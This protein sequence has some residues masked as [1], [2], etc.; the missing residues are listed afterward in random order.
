MD[1]ATLSC[2]WLDL[3]PA[4]PGLPD[5]G[6]HGLLIPIAGAPALRLYQ[7]GKVRLVTLRPGQA[8]LS[9]A[10]SGV[11][12]RAAT[13]F[14]ALLVRIEPRVLADF[15]EGRMYGSLSGGGLAD[16]PVLDDPELCTVARQ[17]AQVLIAGAFGAGVELDALSMVFM[18][19]LTRNHGL[20]T[21]GTRPVSA[22]LSGAQLSRLDRYVVENL[23]GRIHRVDMA[24]AAGTSLSGLVR[25]L[26][27]ALGVTP[28]QYVLHARL[29]AAR[30]RMQDPAASLKAI[31]ADCGFADQA[32]L[33]RAFKARFGQPP[34]AWRLRR[35]AS[36]EAPGG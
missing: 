14:R 3:A 20:V 11:T 13:P 7:A 1:C 19:V 30:S 27:E 6:S 22:R 28:G 10:G 5:N 24:R 23:S 33:S 8:V 12:W 4:Q 31:A 26:R 2:E 17:M 36:A 21:G 32:H 35:A 29:R 34:R 18:V 9:A 15:V 25:G 16:A